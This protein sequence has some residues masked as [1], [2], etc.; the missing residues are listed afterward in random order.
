MQSYKNDDFGRQKLEGRSKNNLHIQCAAFTLQ[1]RFLP[2]FYVKSSSNLKPNDSFEICLSWG[3]Q[4][5]PNMLNLMKFWL[6]YLM[7]KTIQLIPLQNL[8]SS[9]LLFLLQKWSLAFNL[10]YLHQ[11]ERVG[12]ILKSLWWA[13]FKTVIGFQIWSRFHTERGQK[14]SLQSKGG[15]L[16]DDYP[17][18]KQIFIFRSCFGG[19][20]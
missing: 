3:F 15:A 16:Y 9:Q 18:Q 5:I 17:V 6:R 1:Q 19:L 14:P 10:A 20:L 13:D 8:I 12:G 4:N 7:I 11:I 2:F